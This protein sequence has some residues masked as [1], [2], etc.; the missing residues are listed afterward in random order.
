MKSGPLITSAITGTAIKIYMAGKL[1]LCIRR[2]TLL[3]FQSWISGEQNQRFFIE[4]YVNKRSI[5]TEY[6]TEEKWTSVL[7]ILDG[8]YF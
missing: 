4:Y 2:G 3:G 5:T 1:H 7:K 6:D 8:F